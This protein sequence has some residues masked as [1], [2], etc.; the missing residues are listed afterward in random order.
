MTYPAINE[1]Q[2]NR[3]LHTR[4]FREQALLEA[5]H[6]LVG[7]ILKERREALGN[8]DEGAES[9]TP[10]DERNPYSAT[11][12]TVAAVYACDALRFIL[13]ATKEHLV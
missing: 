8:V 11:G 10:G 12:R 5:V 6:T 9:Y 4:Y 3:E 1:I 13:I 2:P 7:Q